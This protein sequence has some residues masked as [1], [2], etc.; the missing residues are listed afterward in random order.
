MSGLETY[1]RGDVTTM[2]QT[3]YRKHD[4]TSEADDVL[5]HCKN[6]VWRGRIAIIKKGETL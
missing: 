1:L 6:H 3:Q 2:M 4:N 5:K